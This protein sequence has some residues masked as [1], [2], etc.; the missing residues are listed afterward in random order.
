MT[1][2]ISYPEISAILN[3]HIKMAFTLSYVSSDKMRIR[4]TPHQLIGQISVDL[5]FYLS[6]SGEFSLSLDSSIP[7][8]DSII[9]GIT[10]FMASKSYAFPY[11]H[12]SD[13][14]IKVNLHKVPQL[15]NILKAISLSSC[16][17]DSTGLTLT[18]NL[19]YHEPESILQ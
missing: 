1:A 12:F 14:H 16:N 13:Q 18:M 7:G 10:T 15:T 17:A 19:N 9:S 8:V 6:P 2:S 4:F 11:L 5:R 3:K